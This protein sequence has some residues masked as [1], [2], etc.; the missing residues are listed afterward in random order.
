MAAPKEYWKLI[1]NTKDYY[2]S[3]YGNIKRKGKILSLCNKDGYYV[4]N[5]KSKTQRVH[6]L[7][8]KTFIAN[9]QNKPYIN[10]INGIRNDNRIENL[11]WCTQS[12]NLKHAYKIGLSK[13]VINTGIKNG[14][15]K[16][17]IDTQTGI[18]YES[19]SELAKLIGVKRTTLTAKLSGQNKNNTNYKYI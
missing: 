2:A 11:E 6:R 14:F 4:V 9:T 17:I 10:H 19:A 1:P 12:E 18:F 13:P 16:Q 15:S 5:I 7:I 3:N 8:A